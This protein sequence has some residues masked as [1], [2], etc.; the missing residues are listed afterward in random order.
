[1]VYTKAGLELA[2][3]TFVNVKGEIVYDELVKPTGMMTDFNT[4]FSGITYEMLKGVTRTLRDAQAEILEFVGAE[5]Y[6]VGHSLESDL[7]A[8]KIVHRRLIDTSELYP[9]TRAVILW[10]AQRDLTQVASIP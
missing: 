9:S 1:M 4:Q 8:L 10:S 2:R 7:R 3:A 5:T 6:L